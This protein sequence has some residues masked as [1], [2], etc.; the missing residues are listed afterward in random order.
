MVH[1][2]LEHENIVKYLT[3][4]EVDCDTICTVMEYCNGLNL[5]EYLNYEK[6]ITE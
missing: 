2:K 5:N 6:R 3:L 4:F 1:Q